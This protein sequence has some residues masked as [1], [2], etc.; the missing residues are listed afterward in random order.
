MKSL[1]ILSE[2]TLIFHWKLVLAYS[3]HQMV[4][5][6]VSETIFIAMLVVKLMIYICLYQVNN[7]VFISFLL[8]HYDL[9]FLYIFYL[10]LYQQSRYDELRRQD[11]GEK[12]L[13]IEQK[14][15]RYIQ[16]CNEVFDP[17]VS[18]IQPHFSIKVQQFVN[19]QRKFKLI[20]KIMKSIR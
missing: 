18:S 8:F 3:K 19:T 4:L 9:V 5:D 14:K 7:F 12:K 16:A 20:C 10:P 2:L 11:R 13:T 15:D 6:F 1:D 17:I